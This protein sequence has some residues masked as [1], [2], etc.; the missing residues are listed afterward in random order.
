MDTAE[1]RRRYDA[2]VSHYTTTPRE[3]AQPAAFADVFDRYR[4]F[5][6]CRNNQENPLL[7]SEALLNKHYREANEALT[8]YENAYICKRNA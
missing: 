4:D 2:V 5:N 7:K 8:V 3:L 6:E 1:L